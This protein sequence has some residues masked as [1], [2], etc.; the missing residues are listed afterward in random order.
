MS[1]KK[2]KKKSSNE[3]LISEMHWNFPTIYISNV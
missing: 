2:T 3:D 1:K